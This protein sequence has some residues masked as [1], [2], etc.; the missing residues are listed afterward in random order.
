MKRIAYLVVVIFLARGTTD[1]KAAKVLAAN[2][3]KAA[4]LTSAH[5]DNPKKISYIL[6]LI[7]ET[8]LNAVVI[9]IKESAVYL[10]PRHIQTIR[11]LKERGIYT[12][13]RIVVFQD[14]VLARERPDLAIKTREG[15]LWRSG[16]FSWNR[17]WT[18]PASAEVAAYNIGV[19]KRAIDAGL[20]ELNFDYIRFP[21]DGNMHD[22]VY[23]VWD[24]A[25][26]KHIVMERFF[27][28]L[29]QELKAYK[30]SIVLSVDIFGYV[31]LN[32]AEMGIGQRLED[33]TK[34]FDVLSPMPYPSH[35]HC[36][37]FGV[38]DP[39]TQ[40]FLVYDR[41]LS[42]GLAK[43]TKM[44]VSPIIRPWI[45]DFSIRN[46]YGCGPPVKYGTVEIRDEIRASQKHGCAG[47]MLWNPSSTF[48]QN[49]LSGK[50]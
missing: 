36:Q 39:N 23:P 4:Y 15:K 11:R 8:E 46:I 7:E 24:G 42:A 14:S 47:F 43:L 10:K 34:Y 31:F 13:G 33:A 30:P 35:Y 19:A 38:P 25:T 26:P 50:K 28:R 49:A 44:G 37:E 1:D 21:S 41:T 5:L 48:T 17:F 45:Q 29:R 22:I 3:I 32:G 20:D 9:D 6:K 18:D 16:R 40:P 2:N 27:V 12:I